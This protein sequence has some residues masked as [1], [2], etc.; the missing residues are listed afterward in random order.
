MKKYD[1]K[2]DIIGDIMNCEKNQQVNPISVP[3]N[4]RIHSFLF[5]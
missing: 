5:E 3:N 1:Q 4:T 2:N